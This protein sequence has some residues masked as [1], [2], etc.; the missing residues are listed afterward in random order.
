MAKQQG[1]SKAEI[2]AIKNSIKELEQLYTKLG[3]INPFKGMDPKKIASSVDEVT[4]LKDELQDA[5]DAVSDIEGEAGDLFKSWRAITDEVKGHRKTINDSKIT[6]SKIN[7]LSQKLKDHQTKVNSLSSKDLDNMVKFV[8][9]ALNDKLYL[10][11]CQIIE[12][13]CS[14]LYSTNSDGYIY[15]KFEEIKEQIVEK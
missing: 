15:V 7:E 9:D 6:V 8:L 3:G 14:K 11:D 10:D 5:R 4:R 12:I 2:D 13:T 1:P